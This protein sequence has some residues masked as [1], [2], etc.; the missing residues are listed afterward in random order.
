MKIEVV[1]EDMGVGENGAN[2]QIALKYC[3]ARPKLDYEKGVYELKDHVKQ[4]ALNSNLSLKFRLAKKTLLA[5]L[6][7]C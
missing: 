4:K 6:S 3:P 1:E 2:A 7:N 5:C